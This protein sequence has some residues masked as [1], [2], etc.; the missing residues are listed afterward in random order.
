[1]TVTLYCPR[2]AELLAVNVSVLPPVVGFGEKEAVT[3]LGRPEAERLTVPAN[4]F[5]GF[6]L[7]EVVPEAPWPMLMP[8][9]ESVKLGTKIPR[10]RVVV[11]V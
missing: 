2:L 5:W 1:V 4:P 3:P 6:T 11:A 10:G 9:P 7:M 8:P